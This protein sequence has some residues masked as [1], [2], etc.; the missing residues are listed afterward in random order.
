MKTVVTILC[1]NSISKPGLLGEHGFSVLIE[2]EGEK[3]LFD[4]GP[5]ISLQYNVKALDKDLN[6][7]NKIF[8]SHGHYDHTG[9]LKW[10]IKQ[11]GTLQVVAHPAM[12][13]AHMSLNPQDKNARYIGCPYTQEELEALGA[14]FNFVDHTT[15]I[16]SGV[17]F[18]TGIDRKSE[19]LPDDP[20]L[21]LKKGDQLIS[22]PMEDDASLLLETEGSPVL[23]VGCA[24]SGVL[25]ILD[26]IK[27][28]MGISKLRAILGGTHLMFFGLKDIPRVINKFEEFSIDLVGVSHCTGIQATIELAKHFGN[29]FM[30]A[31]AGSIFNF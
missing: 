21:K 9:S 18:I 8:I 22:D 11:E 28:K 7:L 24:H 17:W 13:S 27:E 16:I 30:V 6:R 2:R 25:N 29:R 15:E 10:V 31:S 23:I 1:D 19:Q 26:H 5:E 3:Y 4:S 12:F 20:N 14:T